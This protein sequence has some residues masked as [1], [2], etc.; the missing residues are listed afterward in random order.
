MLCNIEVTKV[1]TILSYHKKNSW[2]YMNDVENKYVE[3][4]FSVRGKKK[5]CKLDLNVRTYAQEMYFCIYVTRVSPE[6]SL[7]PI[8]VLTH[9]IVHT[10]ISIYLYVYTIIKKRKSTSKRGAGEISDVNANI[11]GFGDKAGIGKSSVHLRWH[12]DDEYAKLSRE[13]K[14][15]LNQWRTEQRKKNPD[16]G[17]EDSKKRKGGGQ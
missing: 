10:N 5:V 1:M 4:Y 15:E 9:T 12:D 2:I 14:A 3:Y 8:W 17:S 6:S 13:Q 16:F 11:S 7:I